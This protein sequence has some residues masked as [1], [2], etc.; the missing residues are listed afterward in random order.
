MLL[1]IIHRMPAGMAAC[2]L[3]ALLHLIAIGGALAP[4]R[5][6]LERSGSAGAACAAGAQHWRKAGLDA[7]QCR[8][9]AA[10]PVSDDA[11]RRW[12]DGAPERSVLGWCDADY[13]PLLR[14]LPDPP[15]ALFVAGNP[16][17]LWH[18]A[19]AVVGSRMPSAGGRAHAARFASQIAHSGLAV[20]SGLAAGIDGAAHRAALEAAGLTIAVLGTGIDTPYPRQHAALY[21][22][23]ARDGVVVSEYPPGTPARRG[24]FPARN[25]MIAGLS[26]GTLVV[27]AASRSGALITARLAA[28]IGREVFAI[29]GS[30]H[31]PMAKGCHHL[32]RQG[33]AL[34]EDPAEL[35]DALA[36]LAARLGQALRRRLQT[37]APGEEA[38][39]P[40]QPPT[41]PAA[42]RLWQA[43]GHDPVGL[44][45][46]A[47]RT[48]LTIQALSSMLLCMEL[49]GWVA[50]AHGR[51]TRQSGVSRQ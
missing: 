45:Q 40:S 29:P 34:V 36:P 50:V 8:A 28:E 47:E 24:Q 12:L 43:L 26:L 22:Q 9:L 19:L 32:I 46:L 25:R 15:L 37:R 27:E 13:P 2:E 35:I 49:E 51:Y 17:R 41:D 21:Q 7:A 33:A 42:R 30:I 5:R 4:R 3:H 44:D 20:T 31:N 14:D 38:S 39:A 23:I 48:G 11:T 6:L 18:P 1:P 16:A 10:P